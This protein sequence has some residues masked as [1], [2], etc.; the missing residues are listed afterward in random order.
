MVL[1]RWL[2][3][4]WLEA[5]GK[6][7]LFWSIPPRCVVCGREWRPDWRAYIAV[8]GLVREAQVFTKV[9][10]DWYSPQLDIAVDADQM[11]SRVR[12]LCTEH[13]DQWAV[14]EDCHTGLDVRLVLPPSPMR[15]LWR[16]VCYWSGSGMR[17]IWL[18]GRWAWLW[19][20]YKA[21]GYKVDH[22]RGPWP[23]LRVG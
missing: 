8:F 10:R 19:A 6:E 2:R 1:R 20:A 16:D 17:F 22:V 13:G 3:G 4:L 7:N 14:V 9:Y 11:N 18:L 5:Q 21:V 15:R 23:P 12:H